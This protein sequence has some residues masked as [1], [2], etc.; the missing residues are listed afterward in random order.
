VL[1]PGLVGVLFLAACGGDT[2]PPG[3]KPL[4]ERAELSRPILSLWGQG[5]EV[6]MVGG[7]AGAAGLTTLIEHWDGAAWSERPRAG[8]ETLWWVWGT[9]DGA[10]V[11]MV[12]E[13][14]LVLRARGGAIETL[15]SGTGAT[16]YG[17]WGTSAS[18][19]WVV[20]GTPNAGSAQPNDVVLHYT[21]AGF[22]TASG[23]PPKGVA[24]FKVWGAAADDF[25]IVGEGG[26]A[27]RRTAAGW[28]DHS[29]ELMT[30]ESVTT[31]HGCAADDVWAV[32]GANVFHF[33]GARWG[34]AEGAQPSSSANG[35]FC[36]ADGVLVV[37]NGGL[38]LRWVRATNAWS[39][40]S[41]AA[42]YYADFHAAWIAPGGTEWATGG[43]YNAPASEPRVGI[44]AIYGCPVPR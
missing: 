35:V 19:V 41:L 6:W 20:G 4:F 44:A 24:F 3:W 14:G 21:G 9:P 16:L 29:A 33:G 27:W 42:P 10:E 40:D 18:D 22:E 2:C 43:N 32:A 39:D 1:R 15:A 5:R 26:T 36:G 31:V 34:P 11:W 17:V 23:P 13:R 38:K 25:W 12:G 37:G 28:A 8:T 30:R 7:P